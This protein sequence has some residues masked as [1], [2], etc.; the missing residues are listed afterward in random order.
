MNLRSDSAES[1]PCGV[2]TLKSGYVQ[3]ELSQVMEAVRGWLISQ[4]LNSRTFIPTCQPTT[5][6]TASP[7]FG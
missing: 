1:H 5:W 4:K 3:S 7:I 6:R 2:F